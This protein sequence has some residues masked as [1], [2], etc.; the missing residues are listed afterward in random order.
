MSTGMSTIKEVDQAV[1]SFLHYNRSLVI[2]H[3]CS[4]YP[5]AAGDVNL[6]VMR[7]FHKHWGLHTGYDSHDTG[8]AICEAA[9][10]MGAK[11]IEKHLTLDRALEGRNHAMALE[12]E[13]FEKL[14]KDIRLIEKAFG[15]AHKKLLDREIPFRASITGESEEELMKMERS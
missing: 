11:A 13:D 5:A 15:S 7:T 6:R 3:C 8:L 2:M 9:V 10:G 12:P 1:T 4:V 14:V